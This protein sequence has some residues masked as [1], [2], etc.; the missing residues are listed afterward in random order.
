MNIQYK[1]NAHI[2]K[3]Y[4]SELDY[5]AMQLEALVKV[6]RANIY[7]KTDEQDRALTELEYYAQQIKS[8]N[9]S[10]VIMNAD[11]IISYDDKCNEVPF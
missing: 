7:V 1:P 8:R 11:E 10:A 4:T 2:N 3:I 9:Y 6:Y 5:Y